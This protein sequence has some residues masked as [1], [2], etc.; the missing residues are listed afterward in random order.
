MRNKNGRMADIM[1]RIEEKI[2]EIP[3]VDKL[4]AIHGIELK[5]VCDFLAEVGDL[6]T[7]NRCRS[8]QDTQL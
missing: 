1:R 4:L 3:Y 6:I 7:R 8:F 5:T 2:Q